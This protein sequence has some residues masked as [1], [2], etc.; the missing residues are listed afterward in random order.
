[1]RDKSFYLRWNGVGDLFEEAVE[2]V[3]EI[4]RQLPDLPIWL[5][6][7]KAAHAHK[8]LDKRNIWVHFSLDKSSMKRRP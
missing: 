5:V 2:A 1:M 6:T 8:L 7:R 3:L 4:N